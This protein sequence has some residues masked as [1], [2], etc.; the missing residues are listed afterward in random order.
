MR[1]RNAF[2]LFAI[3]AWSQIAIAADVFWLGN[4][5]DVK[6]VDTVTVSGGPWTTGDTATLTCNLQTVTVTVGTSLADADVAAAM[7]AAVNAASATA[8]I[9]AD[10]TRNRG[11]QELGEF[12]DIVASS[13]AAVLTLTSATAGVPYTVTASDT[14]AAGVF[15]TVVSVTSAT[16]KNH[17]DEATNWSTGLVP[18]TTEDVILQDSSVDI[19]Y[20][21]DN[22][23]TP[24]NLKRKN[25]YT[26][27][28]GLPV[29]NTTHSGYTY[30][31]YRQRYL[32]LPMAAPDSAAHRIGETSVATTTSGYTRIDLGT[33]AGTALNVS[34]R[35]AQAW[36]SS[37]GYA[38]DIVGGQNII[39]S[40]YRGSVILGN[41]LAENASELKSLITFSKT[42]PATDA[43]ILVG[44]NVTWDA[45][46]A[47]CTF[48]GGLATLRMPA[49]AA[50][51]IIQ[52]AGSTLEID[53][54]STYDDHTVYGGTVTAIDMDCGDVVLH[55]GAILNCKRAADCNPTNLTVY[56]GATIYDPL[57]VLN[58]TNPI[59]WVNADTIT[60]E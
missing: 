44:E 48:Y 57:G 17:F 39:L 21:L 20:G 52:Y 35:D 28:I 41:D 34:V 53:A 6:Q 37:N 54:T 5:D 1:I 2:L 49:V 25:S 24:L 31:E 56:R 38:V 59:V 15:T 60:V 43:V 50:L 19:L 8:G 46:P 36:S 14:G 55:D 3:L 30:K 13:S 47:A 27:N 45:A 22:T 32:D 4:A 58:S 42:V 40:V 51:D 10:E 29:W 33:V 11:G 23:V 12:R 9:V 26:G 7:A 18:A 16:G